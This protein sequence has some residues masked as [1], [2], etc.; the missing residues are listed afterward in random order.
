MMRVLGAVEAGASPYDDALLARPMT[1]VESVFKQAIESRWPG[2][3]VHVVPWASAHGP[4]TDDSYAPPPAYDSGRHPAHDCSVR[5]GLEPALATGRLAIQT[6]AIVRHVTVDR[7]PNR[8]SGVAYVDAASGKLLEA[9]ARAIMLCASTLESTRILLNSRSDG[10]LDGL[11]NSS[12]VLG[13]YLV[14]HLFGIGAMGI[15]RK[16]SEPHSHPPLWIPPFRNVPGD[17]EEHGFLRG[18]QLNCSF[19]GMRAGLLH[20]YRQIVAVMADGEVL[21]RFENKVSIDDSVV[22]RWGIPVLRIEYRRGENEELMCRDMMESIEEIMEV[23][24]YKVFYRARHSLPPGM[25][26]HELGT[27][28][29]GRNPKTSVV[30]PF[31]CTW[32]V[33]NLYVTDGAVFP[34]A[35]SQN[36]TLAM[37]ALTARACD[38][39]TDR[40]AHGDL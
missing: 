18:Y 17:Q 36:P 2:R 22:D 29:M 1:P 26:I 9:R 28:R 6:G 30:D 3:R 15:S 8:A 12:G 32:D 35:G 27:A 5:W 11:A 38:H 24:G 19:A 10:A 23:A 25:S 14:D 34:S 13:H 21:P 20:R 31:C 39:I 40:M 33:R 7:N 37:M 4:G 16:R